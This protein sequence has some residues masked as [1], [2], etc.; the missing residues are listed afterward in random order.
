MTFLNLPKKWIQKKGFTII[1]T[2]IGFLSVNLQSLE[3]II[4]NLD[5]SFDL[6]GV[7]ET[8]SPKINQN[9]QNKKMV[10]GYQPYYGTE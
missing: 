7:S 3:L 6:I 1:H 8:W 9:S 5:N 4:A 2:N 10:P